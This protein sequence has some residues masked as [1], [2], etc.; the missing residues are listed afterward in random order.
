MRRFVVMLGAIVTATAV[1]LGPATPSGAGGVAPSRPH[2][3][4]QGTHRASPDGPGRYAVGLS[5]VRMVDPARAD[6]TLTVDIWYPADGRSEAPPASLDLVLTRLAL[7]GGARKYEQRASSPRPVR[8]TTR[9]RSILFSSRWWFSVPGRT[10]GRTRTP[11]P[12][13]GTARTRRA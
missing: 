8:P 10:P 5:T 3:P 11:R 4:S 9:Y 1:L 2:G 6:R 12:G 7:P 13:A